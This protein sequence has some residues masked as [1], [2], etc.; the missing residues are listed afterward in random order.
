M[1]DSPLRL[2]LLGHPVAHSISP[3][4][5]NAALRSAGL[6]LSYEARDVEPGALDAAYGKNPMGFTLFAKFSLGH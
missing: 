4:I 3:R 2:L 5:Q 1:I 6:S